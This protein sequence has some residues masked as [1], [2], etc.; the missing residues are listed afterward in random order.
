M[1]RKFKYN[2]KE[3]TL[4]AA[5]KGTPAKLFKYWTEKRLLCKWFLADAE[6]QLKKNG[7]YMFQWIEGSRENGKILEVRKNSLLRF[8]FAGGKCEVNF[9]KSG[10]ECIVTLKQ[11]EIPD[12]QINRIRIHMGCQIGWVF[13]FSNLKSVIE[14]GTDLREH[15]P[16][17]L[18]EGTVFY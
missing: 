6:M 13:F 10:K 17:H 16:K 1:A 15:N 9:K 3:F 18:K 11:Y 2:W 14:S 8:T 4:R 12:D 5:F 7:D